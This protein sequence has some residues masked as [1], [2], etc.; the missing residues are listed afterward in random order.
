MAYIQVYQYTHIFI[1]RQLFFNK[2]TCTKILY[3]ALCTY[4]PCLAF[5]LSIFKLFW[6][7]PRP[8]C[9][10][11]TIHNPFW[12]N[13]SGVIVAVS[14][15]GKGVYPPPNVQLYLGEN[16]DHKGGSFVP[17]FRTILSHFD[18]LMIFL[19]VLIRGC[20]YGEIC[21]TACKCPSVGSLW[22]GGWQYGE[23]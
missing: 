5:F 10:K 20:L 16:L 1:N 7:I 11:S 12:W 21:A 17:H 19:L 15:Q 8:F 14:L 22:R 2:K 23:H 18:F 13:F 4:S 9:Y 3:N 6:Y